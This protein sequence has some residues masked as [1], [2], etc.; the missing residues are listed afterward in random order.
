[1]AKRDY[2]E[3]LGISKGASAE[4]IKK[5]YRKLAIQYHPDKNQGNKNA[6]EKFK[7][8][9]EAYEVL[10]DEKKRRAYDQYG[11]DGVEGMGGPSFNASAFSGFEDIFGDFSSIFESFFG[12]GGRTRS[13][14]RRGGPIDGNDLRYDLEIDFRDAV[15]GTKR[16]ISYHHLANCET[17]KGSG[18]KNGSGRKTCPVCHG[19]GQI[20]R[21]SG[22]FAI[23]STCSQCN[24][25]GS[26]IENPCPACHGNGVTDKHKRVNVTIPAGIGN[27]KRIRLSGQ[28]DAGRQGGSP[29]DL[30]VYLRV[31]SHPFYERSDNDLYCAVPVSF[32]MA[33]MGGEI[34]VKTLDD[35]KIKLKVPAGTQHGKLLRIKNEGV[36]LLQSPARRGDLYVKLHIQIPGRLNSKE[37]D[38]LKQF[39]DIH[40]ENTDP[41][42]IPLRDL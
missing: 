34:T 11:F 2:Y 4:E 20:R 1:V 41:D 14:S 17:C 23:A 3:V 28:G 25:T 10:S 35:K 9:T 5:A 22:F 39:S 7:E 32:T 8:A 13:S 37:K 6:E 38:L 31:K 24:G 18:S 42:L 21:S 29:G 36:P 30:Y 27:G 16:E 19:T 15:F 12:G 40:G 33:A 26:I